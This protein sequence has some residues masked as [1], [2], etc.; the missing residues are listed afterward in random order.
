MPNHRPISAKP[1][2]WSLERAKL[3]VACCQ[4]IFL[5]QRR[6]VRGRAVLDACQLFNNSRQVKRHG[7][8]LLPSAM[9]AHYRRWLDCPEVG[10]FIDHRGGGT[11]RKLSPGRA[12]QLGRRAIAQRIRVSE[13]YRGLKPQKHS[14]P[15]CDDTLRKVLPV[16]AL[17]ELSLAQAALNK[18]ES[19]ALVAL[20]AI[21]KAA[22]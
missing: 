16:Q 19:R 22:A 1:V 6:G 21:T 15:F 7:T 13:L 10:N 4:G 11:P 17:R 12:R 8:R 18:A 9:R 2:P 20:D 14:V 5:A 3:I